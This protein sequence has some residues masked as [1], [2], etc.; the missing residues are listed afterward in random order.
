MQRTTI[1]MKLMLAVAALSLSACS[2][3]TQSSIGTAATMP[4]NDLNIVRADIPDALEQAQK[5]PYAVPADQSCPAISLQIRALDEVLGADLDTPATDAN[6]SL[7]ER[8]SGTAKN[9][10][11]GA[12]QRTAE[13]VVP[14]RSWVRK[15]SGAERY[16]KHVAAA[17]A[18]GT[19]RRAF[20]KGIGTTHGCAYGTPVSVAS[21]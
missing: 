8:G 3:T 14:F 10:A 11:L 17:I 4:L 6:P 20:L 18:A 16:S 7:I 19:A 15:L 5:Q 2:T 12:L 13:G 9:Y 21:Q 1:A